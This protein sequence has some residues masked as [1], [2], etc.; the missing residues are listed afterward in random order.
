MLLKLHPADLEEILV[1]LHANHRGIMNRRGI[2]VLY[3]ESSTVLQAES[4]IYDDARFIARNYQLQH[5]G[6]PSNFEE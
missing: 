6:Q 1:S 5:A 4:L 2:M 3:I